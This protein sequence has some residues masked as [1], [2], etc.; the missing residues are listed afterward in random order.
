MPGLMDRAGSQNR[1]SWAAAPGL[2]SS[3]RLATAL[4]GGCLRCL[5]RACSLKQCLRS[6]GEGR[7]AEI[8]SGYFRAKCSQLLQ[9]CRGWGGEGV[10]SLSLCG[11]PHQRGLSVLI[12]KLEDLGNTH[13]RAPLITESESLM[14]F[15]FPLKDPTLANTDPNQGL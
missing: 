8:G 4:R 14:N 7:A 13:F 10:E 9:L 15:F 1:P 6:T 3:A 12:S 2:C 5:F 11:L